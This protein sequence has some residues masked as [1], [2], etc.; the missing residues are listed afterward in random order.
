LRCRISVESSFTEMTVSRPSFVPVQ[1]AAE[2]RGFYPFSASGA[3]AAAV[4]R[5][6]FFVS[7]KVPLN[8]DITDAVT[9]DR[10][11][12][13]RRAAF[14]LDQRCAKQLTTSGTHELGTFFADLGAEALIAAHTRGTSQV[15]TCVTSAQ[16]AHPVRHRLFGCDRRPTATLEPLR[17]RP[18]I[19][20]QTQES[21]PGIAPKTLAQTTDLQA[22]CVTSAQLE[23]IEHLGPRC[24]SGRL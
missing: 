17:P 10:A 6:P 7:Q 22:I 8:G 2:L 12:R 21:T 4:T 15:V 9:S 11:A 3:A 13:F 16:R 19:G 1:I 5:G 23:L 20:I 18:T 14:S 24:F